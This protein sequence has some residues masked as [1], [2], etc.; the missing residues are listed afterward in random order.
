[1]LV[2]PLNQKIAERISLIR[3]PMIFLIVVSHVPWLVR[4][5][6]DPTLLTFVGTFVTDGLIRLAIPMLSC[7]SGFLIFYKAMDSNFPLL[8]RKRFIALVLPLLIWNIPVVLAL[9]V[10]QSQGLIDYE[11]AYRKTMYPVDLMVWVNG[12][13]SITD[14][15]INYPMHFLRDL[16][17]VTLFVPLMSMLLRNFPFVGLIALLAFF[18]PNL[19]GLLIRNNTIIITFYIGG[20]AATMNWNLKWLDIYAVP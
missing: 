2:S 12:V 13:L 19:D 17:V 20:M 7:I 11:F 6:D 9:Y 15:P 1:M 18:I 16:F 5:V 8:L 14:F 4:Y 10:V 3:Y